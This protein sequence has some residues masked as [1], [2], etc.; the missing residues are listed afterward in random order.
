MVAAA[1]PGDGRA[2]AVLA[3]AGTIAL[4]AARRAAGRGRAARGAPAGRSLRCCPSRTVSKPGRWD[5][6]ARGVTEEVIADLA[7]NSWIFVLADA[8][9]RPH[10][11]ETPQAVGTALGA[12]HVVTGTI[13][14]E[15]D[16]VRV[17]AALA[18]AASGRQRWARQWDGPTDDL[19]AIQAAAAEALVGELAGPYYGAIARA[20]RDRRRAPEGGQ[21]AR[22]TS[23]ICSAS[24]TSR[25]DYSLFLSLDESLPETG[26]RSRPAVRKGLGGS[27]RISRACGRPAQ[28]PRPNS[29]GSGKSAAPTSAKAVEADP[30]DPGVL[31]E[32]AKQAARDGDQAAVARALR[33]AIERWRRTTLTSSP[34]RLG[35]RPRARRSGRRP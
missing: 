21:P 23:S 6:L 31:I 35:S 14:A 8:T 7:T 20:D 34:A 24:S 4:V 27:G 18:D 13:Q 29:A 1:V 17:T 32:V 12:S 9:T 10:A 33:R 16:R 25:K 2:L 3:I 26:G 22:P 30:D 5:R 19:L 15:G 28:Q 11:G